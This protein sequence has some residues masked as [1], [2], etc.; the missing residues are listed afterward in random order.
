VYDAEVAIEMWHPRLETFRV[1][2]LTDPQQAVVLR[3]QGWEPSEP[4]PALA[5]TWGHLVTTRQP[6]MGADGYPTHSAHLVIR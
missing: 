5:R 3:A 4:T 1:W 2:V 6:E